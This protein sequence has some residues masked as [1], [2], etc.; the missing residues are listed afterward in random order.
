MSAAMGHRKEAKKWRQ[1]LVT[2][3]RL[4]VQSLSCYH[5]TNLLYRL[6]AASRAVTRW[7]ECRNDRA[8]RLM[9]VLTS[10]VNLSRHFYRYS[11]APLSD[12]VKY[13]F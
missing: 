1:M 13:K 11:I 4:Q 7:D 10:R 12:Y 8:F 6:L 2:I 3:Q 5:Y 9:R